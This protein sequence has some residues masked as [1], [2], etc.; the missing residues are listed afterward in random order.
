MNQR[1]TIEI[2]FWKLLKVNYVI[3]LKHR[4]KGTYLLLNTVF[5]LET[6]I[7]ITISIQTSPNQNLLCMEHVYLQRCEKSSFLE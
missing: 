4:F 6:P 1:Y 7:G 3:S 5:A 2:S